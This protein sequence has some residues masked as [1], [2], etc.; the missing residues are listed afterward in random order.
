MYV[1]FYICI[2]LSE[3]KTE[4]HSMTS[5]KDEKQP[6]QS[7]E[8]RQEDEEKLL[9]RNIYEELAQL[10]RAMAQPTRLEIIDLL[11][12]RDHSVDELAKAIGTSHANL[13]HHIQYLKKAHLVEATKRGRENI[14]RIP[15]RGILEVWD[16]MR[17]LGLSRNPELERLLQE[18]HGKNEEVA[19][20]AEDLKR[21]LHD[22]ELVLVDVR[23]EEEYQAGHIADALSIPHDR[24]E[25]ELSKLPKDKGIVAYC[26]GPFCVMSDKA[27]EVLRS[28]GY[29]VTSFQEGFTGWVEKGY[30]V[31]RPSKGKDQR[32]RGWG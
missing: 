18:L 2:A 32:T 27:V 9:Q 31:K 17:K 23:P 5:K 28:H 16:R 14:Y 1:C 12:Q 4:L 26:R 13:S 19:F 29:K 22:E 24:I 11:S 30:P 21:K 6:L 7:P 3:P 20:S 8:N 10:S 15:E 25:Q